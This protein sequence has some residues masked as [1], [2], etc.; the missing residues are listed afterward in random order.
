M[1]G[2][3]NKISNDDL[4]ADGTVQPQPQDFTYFYGDP[5]CR[6]KV[7][8]TSPCSYQPELVRFWFS[9]ILDNAVFVSPFKNG[10]GSF[11]L[12]KITFFLLNLGYECFFF[13]LTNIFYLRLELLSI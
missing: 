10:A 4:E 13:L 2:K 11:Q 3:Y 6:E 9:V 5:V 7:E 12:V 8:L 1:C